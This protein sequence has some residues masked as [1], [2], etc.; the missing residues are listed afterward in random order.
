MTEPF[1]YL[2]TA[3][4]GVAMGAM[5]LVWLLARIINNAGIVDVAWALGFAVLAAIYF[6]L[7]EGDPPRKQLICAMVTLWS[8]RLGGY[9]WIR[10]ARHHPIED[11]R[12]AALREQY[13]RH[14]WLMF[15]GFFQLQAVLLAILS[16]PFAMAAEPD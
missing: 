4:A 5:V 9:L 14:T 1:W 8:L 2:L 15:F 10:V 16:V 12:Y 13:P 11:G 3:G 6:L 7:G